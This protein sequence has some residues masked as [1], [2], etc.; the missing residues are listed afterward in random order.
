MS[1]N[2]EKGCYVLLLELP[3]NRVIRVGELGAVLFPK[4]IYAYVGSAMSGLGQR[5]A[6]HLK[7]DK[8]RHWH[9][10]YLS[11][12]AETR[13]VITL[14]TE[15]RLECALAGAL[16]RD[17]RGVSRFGSSDCA[18]KSHLFY[19]ESLKE[20]EPRALEITSSLKPG[21]VDYAR[22]RTKPREKK[23]RL[24]SGRE[25]L[26]GGSLPPTSIR[27]EGYFFW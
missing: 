9:I 16:A 12:E 11:K 27:L 18:C 26:P 25:P 3:Q 8:T 21:L 2:V 24:V 17:Y 4:G 5:V 20:M 22:I 19:A 1:H 14:R 10:D 23:P 13:G 15:E 6:R 7:K